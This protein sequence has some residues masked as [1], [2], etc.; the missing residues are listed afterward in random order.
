MAKS[1][2]II[3]CYCMDCGEVSSPAVMYMVIQEVWDSVVPHYHGDL[4]LICLSKRLGRPLIQADFNTAPINADIEFRLAVADWTPEIAREAMTRWH[5]TA[6]GSRIMRL[7]N[8][9]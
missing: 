8:G 3:A 1:V 5:N 9:S 4:C 6:G 2:K 7:I